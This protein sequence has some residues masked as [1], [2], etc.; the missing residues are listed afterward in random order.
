MAKSIKKTNAARLLDELR[1]PYT[2][3]SFTVDETD[4]SAVAAAAALGAQ[5]EQVFKTL[6]VHGDKYGV[7][8]AC[9]PANADLALKK[10]AQ[11]SNNK[12]VRLVP[13]REVLG[14]TGYVRGGCSPLGTK[15]VY[16]VYIDHSALLFD[17][18][19]ISAGQRGLQFLIA[20]H[21]LI[22]TTSATLGEFA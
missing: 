17:H 7:L 21:D 22:R 20:P 12:S 1:I 2:L 11:T 18:I 9:I 13:L 8:L 14:L 3:Q 16:P 4:L 10:L 6:V 19:Y 5:P 15:K